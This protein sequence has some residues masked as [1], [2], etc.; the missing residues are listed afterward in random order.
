[1]SKMIVEKPR[2][3]NGELTSF[4]K[5]YDEII[6]KIEQIQNW[7]ENDIS[8]NLPKLKDVNLSASDAP[9]KVI[10][11]SKDI[12]ISPTNSVIMPLPF[13]Y[14]NNIATHVKASA[15]QEVLPARTRLLAFPHNTIFDQYYKI[16][17]KYQNDVL[18][19]LARYTLSSCV[20]LGINNILVSGY[21]QGASVGAKV[22]SLASAYDIKV[23]GALLGES[24]NT[25]ERSIDEIRKDYS[26][27]TMSPNIAL[28]DSGIKLL[29]RID[30]PSSSVPSLTLVSK[31]IKIGLMEY[32]NQACA[33]HE[34]VTG[35]DFVNDLKESQR[36]FDDL[37]DSRLAVIGMSL[38]KVMV[39]SLVDNFFEDDQDIRVHYYE[40]NG[41]GHEG[42]D[43]VIDW[44]LR[45]RQVV[46]ASDFVNS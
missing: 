22:V 4:E 45:T 8:D 17:N 25:I 32:I 15:I 2:C 18:D 7:D 24:P 43:N 38:S 36:E 39:A 42:G 5:S 23:S 1:M 46:V 28:K 33:L 35:N 40:V 12:E 34:S 19:A 9:L 6:T 26:S 27:S 11:F 37:A 31:F 30:L 29:S 41:Y 21:S 44:A 13:G 10:D 14:S 3:V 16:D 20:S